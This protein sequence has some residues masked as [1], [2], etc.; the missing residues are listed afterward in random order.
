MTAARSAKIDIVA[1]V[2]MY[3]GLGQHGVVLKLCLAD[4]LAIVGDNNQLGT[5]LAQRRQ[6]LAESKT[7]LSRLHHQLDLGVDRVHLSFALLHHFERTVVKRGWENRHFVK[8]RKKTS[9]ESCTNSTRL[10][11]LG[12][13]IL[14]RVPDRSPLCNTRWVVKGS[15]ISF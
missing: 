8:M 9:V 4:W 11:L 10:N 5:T 6:S 1:A 15:S 12:S 2:V 3:R 7:V 13:Y 14:G